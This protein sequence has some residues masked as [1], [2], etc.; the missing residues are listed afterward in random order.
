MFDDVRT[1]LIEQKLTLRLINDIMLSVS[2]AFTNALLHGNQSDPDKSIQISITANNN[3]I[4]ADITDEGHGDVENLGGQKKVDL[5]QEDGRGMML[6]KAMA[7][8]ITFR[9]STD[10][11]GTLVSIKFDRNKYNISTYRHFYFNYSDEYKNK[12]DFHVVWD[13]T[14]KQGDPL[15]FRQVSYE[16]INLVNSSIERID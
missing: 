15:D 1:F 16:P 10:T 3:E 5:W 6:M 11:G 2:E 7:S 13:I 8:G 4:T 9:K 12:Y 14:Y